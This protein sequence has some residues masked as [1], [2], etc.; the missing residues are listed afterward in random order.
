MGCVATIAA[1]KFPKQGS[2]IGKRAEVCFNYDTKYLFMGTFVR[3]DREDPW[4]TIIHL[5]DGRFVL[6]TE[7]QY[8][9][10]K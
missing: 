1:D 9:P 8:S 6:A 4:V 7:C 3:D 5:D 10:G 2:W